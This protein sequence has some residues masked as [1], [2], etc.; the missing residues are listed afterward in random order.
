MHYGPRMMATA[1]APAAVVVTG[2]PATGKSTVGRLLAG[3][4]GA[5]LVDQDTATAPLVAV[6]ADLV[7]TADLDDPRLAGPTRAARYDTVVALAEDNL[8]AGLPVVLV[9]PFTTERGDPAAWER[10]AARLR[11]AGG[12]PVLVWLRLD[13]EKVVA[14]LR[15]RSAER[16]AAKVAEPAEYVRRLAAA[17]GGGAPA[18][19]HL[20][21]DADQPAAAV[22]A[23]VLAAL[24]PS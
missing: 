24:A 23:E 3:H 21:V 12:S 1:P 10:L 16:D 4:L 11:S 13:P 5:A 6:V 14:R 17:A 15:A 19:P 18:A 8:R 20:A 7:G 2:W 22:A 9:A